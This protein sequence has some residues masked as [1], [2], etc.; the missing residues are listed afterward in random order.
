MTISETSL[1]IRS[2]R[3][4]RLRLF[5]SCTPPLER[6]LE[7]HFHPEIEIHVIT[8]GGGIYKIEGQEQTFRAGDVFIFRTNE[9]HFV[10]QRTADRDDLSYSCG[11]YFFP[12]LIQ[13]LDSDIFDT[14]YM[15]VFSR[16]NDHFIHYI[17]S[18][19]PEAGRIA[20]MMD[21]IQNE[22]ESA[23]SGFEMMIML[24]LMNIIVTYVRMYPPDLID[25]ICAGREV[26]SDYYEDIINVMKYID[27][28]ITEDISIDTLAE[29]VNMS[30][31]C[32]SKWFKKINGYTT[33]D[34]INTQR[35]LRAQRLLRETNLSVT[36]IAAQCGFNNSANF[37][38]Q[39]KRFSGETPTAFRK[40]L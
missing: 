14:K 21:A 9:K 35:V 5:Q 18:E 8:D 16:N 26:R 32:Y 33:W 29:L 15:Q 10:T 34:Y 39:F 38:R 40:L 27:E 11:L 19:K 20:E 36:K 3:K 6:T 7:E 2:Q 13:Y 28:H 37:N 4:A 31:S 17:P 30:A 24:D 22:F 23:E 12:E 25:E 1:P